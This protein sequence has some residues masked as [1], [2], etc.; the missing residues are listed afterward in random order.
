MTNAVVR[1]NPDNAGKQPIDVPVVMGGP[2]GY[3]STLTVKAIVHHLRQ[4]GI[5]AAVSH[6]AG[7]YKLQPAVLWAESSGQ[8]QH[9]I[10][11]DD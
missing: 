4:S 7:T 9:D 1:G 5:P 8:T 10:S 11:D 6:T 2:V 3:F